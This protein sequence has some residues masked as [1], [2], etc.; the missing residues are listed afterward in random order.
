MDGTTSSTEM[1]EPVPEVREVR[2]AIVAL[3]LLAVS[4][5]VE[6]VTVGNEVSS[7]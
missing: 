2:S 3:G 5:E 1:N 6:V 4:T 7:G